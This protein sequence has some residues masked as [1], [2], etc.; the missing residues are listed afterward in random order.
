MLLHIPDFP[1]KPSDSPAIPPVYYIIWVLCFCCQS[2][3]QVEE[4]CPEMHKNKLGI[5]EPQDVHWKTSI[6]IM[7]SNVLFSFALWIYHFLNPEEEL[8]Q[9][10]STN[11]MAWST[12]L[13]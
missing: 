5:Y 3:Q 10:K 8:Q 12:Q 2:Q 9:V 1:R 6:Y 4:P 7:S 11:R 13:Q